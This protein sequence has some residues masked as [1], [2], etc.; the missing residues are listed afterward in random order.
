MGRK[1]SEI[2]PVVLE[3]TFIAEKHYY[4]T[5]AQAIEHLYGNFPWSYQRLPNR[6]YITNGFLATVSFRQDH[7]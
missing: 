6:V 2:K 7:N 3:V 1:Y 5:R 4:F